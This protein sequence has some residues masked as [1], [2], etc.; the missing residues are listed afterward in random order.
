MSAL[1]LPTGEN[2]LMAA[3]RSVAEGRNAD[4]KELVATYQQ[5]FKSAVPVP[6]A[7]P[8]FFERFSLVDPNIRMTVQSTTATD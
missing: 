7:Q 8:R 4:P 6:P 1:H 5:H 3:F 2:I